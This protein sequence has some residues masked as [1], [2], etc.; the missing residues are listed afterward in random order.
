VRGPKACT[1][2]VVEVGVNHHERNLVHGDVVNIRINTVHVNVG[3]HLV[4]RWDRFY[5]R[6]NHLWRGTTHSIR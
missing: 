2:I 3:V 5:V 4:W 1:T 6:G